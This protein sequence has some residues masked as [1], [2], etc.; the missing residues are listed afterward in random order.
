MTTRRAPAPGKTFKGNRE[1]P[2][3]QHLP[4]EADLE[5][6]RIH[7]NLGGHTRHVG[8][9]DDGVIGDRLQ[10]PLEAS[11]A[12]RRSRASIR[13]LS[14]A[15]LPLAHGGRHRNQPAQG[16]RRL[17]PLRRRLVQGRAAGPALPV[18]P[19]RRREDDPAPD[20]GRRDR[21]ARRRAR[22]REGDAD[23]AA[24]PAPAA[25]ARAVVARVRALRR[26]R[27]DRDRGGAGARSSRRWPAAST[28]RRRCAATPRRRRV[29]STQAATPGASVSTRPFAASASGT[30][31]ST[32]RWTPSP[33]AS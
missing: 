6:L 2:E 19:E 21:A 16:D 10:L 3:P 8:D 26:R 28:T 27:P 20:P 31:T 24:R 17:A 30:R 13:R 11:I 9:P 14:Y 29:S 33:A 25:R 15:G 4:Q 7:P 5:I 12:V 1:V 23:R 22:L 32:G 18:R